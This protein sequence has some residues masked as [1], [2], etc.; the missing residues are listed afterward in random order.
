MN[1]RE[2]EG[3]PPIAQHLAGRLLLLLLPS[4]PLAPTSQAISQL[5]LDTDSDLEP[6]TAR[7]KAY[8]DLSHQRLWGHF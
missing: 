3:E 1:D 5:A 6:V 2:D 8:Y 4:L 7:S